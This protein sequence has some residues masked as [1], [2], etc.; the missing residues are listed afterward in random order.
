MRESTSTICFSRFTYTPVAASAAP[1]DSF[2]LVKLGKTSLRVSSNS[3]S[4]YGT[5]TMLDAR[6]KALECLESLECLKSLT[7]SSAVVK[8]VLV[9]VI[10]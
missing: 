3:V 6:S 9:D 2:R 8:G 7:S 4:V 5:K 1:C 10:K